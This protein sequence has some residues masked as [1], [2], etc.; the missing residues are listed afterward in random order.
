MF[1]DLQAT[2]RKLAAD[3]PDLV[4][5]VSDQV[6]ERVGDLADERT[7]GKF[8]DKVDLAQGR[9]DDAVGR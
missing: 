5:K 8:A 6:I 7:G 2:A 4:E 3:H 9:A 1:D